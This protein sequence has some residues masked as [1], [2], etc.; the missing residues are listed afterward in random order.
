LYV[1]SILRTRAWFANELHKLGVKTYPSAGNFLLADFGPRGSEMCAQL[2]KQGV[3]LRDRAKEI[4][5]GFVRV[6]IGTQKEME[7]LLKLIK[8]YR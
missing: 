3:L 4:G 2:E 5:P 6:S 1:K 8:R 7:R